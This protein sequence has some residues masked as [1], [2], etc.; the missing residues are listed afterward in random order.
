MSEG[1]FY[2]SLCILPVLS[3]LISIAFVF[4]FISSLDN[5]LVEFLNLSLSKGA[6][7]VSSLRVNFSNDIYIA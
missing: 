1:C 4:N 5:R 3:L 7:F 6:T 2:V